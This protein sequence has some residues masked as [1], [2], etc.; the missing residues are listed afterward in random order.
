MVGENAVVDTDIAVAHWGEHANGGGDRLAWELVRALD[1]PPFYVG[2]RDESIEPNDID[3]K[4]LINGWWMERALSSGGLSRKLA[5]MLGWQIAAPLR[6]YDVIL[7]SGNEPLFYVAP[8]DQTWIA[9]IHHTNRRQSDQITEIESKPF[10]SIRLL[11]HYLIR[12]LFDHNTNKPDLFVVNSEIVKRRVKRYW[13]VPERKISVV[14]PPVDTHTYDPTEADTEDFYVTLSRLD[15]HKDIDSI[16]ET[17]NHLSKRLIVVGDGPERERLEAMA[18]DTIEFT[19]FVD[20][21]EKR[22]LLSGAKAFVFNARDEDFGIAPVEA[23]AAGTPLLGINEGMTQFQVIEGKNG[24]RHTRPGEEGPSLVDT[25]R[26]F[27]RD[28]VQ[29][30]PDTI[31]SFADRF[32]VDAFEEGIRDAIAQAVSESSVTPSWYSENGS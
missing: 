21:Q 14:Y 1:Y 30:D 11:F 9:Y 2:W 16:I 27:E 25:V 23:L 15:W 20:E 4:A 6:E 3:P 19:G 10:T 12:V 24:Y 5:H 26:Q 32:S 18:G 17:F 29:W 13:G 22:R 28:G 7:T 8:D 31:A